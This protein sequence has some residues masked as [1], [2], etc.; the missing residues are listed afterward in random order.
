VCD[1]M[2]T[3]KTTSDATTRVRDMAEIHPEDVRQ[4]LLA[5][6]RRR[7]WA[8]VWLDGRY[9]IRIPLSELIDIAEMEDFGGGLLTPAAQA[10]W[11]ERRK[12]ANA[13]LEEL[14]REAERRAQRPEK[15]A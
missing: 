7:R 6:L 9:G 13:E 15:V 10:R 4:A 3:S 14:R 2:L 12:I 11:I 8:H 5:H 1:H